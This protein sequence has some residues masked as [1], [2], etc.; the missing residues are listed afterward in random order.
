MIDGPFTFLAQKRSLLAVISFAEL[1]CAPARKHIR[2]LRHT[3]KSTLT[4]WIHV[5][6]K[7]MKE[8]C[9]NDPR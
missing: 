6:S 5:D 4:E 3:E 8:E 2:P 9:M 7:M 1:I